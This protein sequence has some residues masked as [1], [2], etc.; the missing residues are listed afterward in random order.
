MSQLFKF[1]IEKCWD[2]IPENRPTTEQLYD[3]IWSIRDYE[4]DY[5][6]NTLHFQYYSSLES[7]KTNEEIRKCVGLEKQKWKELDEEMKLKKS[8]PT[9]TSK[10][11]QIHSNAVYTSRMFTSKL[12][13]IPTDTGIFFISKYNSY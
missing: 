12:I 2:P 6:P 3:F 10:K 1:I 11:Q 8:I 9:N 7:P 13:P 4:E 5:E